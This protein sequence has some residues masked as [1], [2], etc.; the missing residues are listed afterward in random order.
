MNSEQDKSAKLSIFSIYVDFISIINVAEM[1]IFRKF[2]FHKKHFED[3]LPTGGR[4]SETDSQTD[5][6]FESCNNNINVTNDID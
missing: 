1:V 5:N 3:Q 6:R 2:S 4:Y